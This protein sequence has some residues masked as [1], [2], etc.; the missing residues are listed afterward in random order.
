M[1]EVE[2]WQ[3]QIV[4]KVGC[5]ER[6]KEKGAS[7][8][9]GISLYQ[10]V[11]LAALPIGKRSWTRE[12]T[13]PPTGIRKFDLQGSTVSPLTVITP[14]GKPKPVPVYGHCNKVPPPCQVP[15]SLA[16]ILHSTFIN[17]H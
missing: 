10:S 6:K 7:R 9:V 16:P 17:L 12:G 8:R 13:P 1:T 11:R 4:M 3:V 15:C 5:C 14:P 2:S